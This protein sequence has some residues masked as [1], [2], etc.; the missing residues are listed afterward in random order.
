MSNRGD[1]PPCRGR[2]RVVVKRDRTYRCSPFRIASTVSTGSRPIR[3][4]SS[5]L[6][7]VRTCDTFT[8]LAFGR[9]ASP[10]RKATF[11]GA[12][13]LP[14]FDVTRQTTLVAIRLELNKS[15][16]ITT[17]G[18]RSAGADPATGPKSSQNT[19][20]WRILPGASLRSRT[21]SPRPLTSSQRSSPGILPSAASP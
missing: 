11:P 19:S 14:E 3:S 10:L 18:W 6:S 16:C 17:Q 21:T 12:F 5:D 4:T 7:T 13:A 8:T 1:L 2:A 20:P 9:L 15:L